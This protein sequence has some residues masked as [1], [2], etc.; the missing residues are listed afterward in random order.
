MKR[1]LYASVLAAALLAPAQPAFATTSSNGTGQIQWNTSPTA[2]LA[3]VTQYNAAFAQG[4]AAPSLLPSPATA[5]STPASESNF[6]ISFGAFTPLRNAP[7]A[8]LYKN[9]LAV[10][11]STN[12]FS[13]FTVN[14]YLDSA[15]AGIGVCAFPNGGAT[16]PLAPSAN[17]TV[18]ARGAA[19]APG[20][21]TGNVL[22]SCAAGG[23]LVPLG[24]GGA[25]SAGTTPGNPGTP[26][27]E[28]YSPSTSQLQFVFQN[29]TTS[30]VAV[31]GGEDL[32]L[33]LAPGEPST[34]ATASVYITIQLIPN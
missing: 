15:P 30:N 9:A 23:T 18:S 10:S 3:I 13:G 32:Q 20:T 11:V 29:S 34:T 1:L 14:Q 17:A 8:C 33:N 5:C 7:V 19:P 2:S 26:S 24:T 4:N 16:F 12:D 28:F 31:F 6:T 25:S 27:L 22:T 21:F